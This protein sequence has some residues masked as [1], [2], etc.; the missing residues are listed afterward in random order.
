M[1]KLSVLFACAVLFAACAGNKNILNERMSKYPAEKYI[2]RIAAAPTKAAARAAA[3][4]DL[5]K[6][7]DGVP[8]SEG[9]EIRRQSILARASVVQWWRDKATDRFYAIAALE[10]AG[11]QTTM[12]PFYA[13]IDARLEAIVQRMDG[14]QDKFARLRSAMAMQPLLEQ[15]ENLDREFRLLS[16]DSGAFNEDRLFVFRTAYNKAF[17]DIR[18][19]AKLTGTGDLAVKTHLVDALNRLGF[20]VGENMTSA[21]IELSIDTR[22]THT[23]SKRVD[24]L[25]WADSTATIA[26]KDLETGG[27]FATFDKFGRDGSGRAEEAQRRSMIAVG[28]DSAPIIKQR[29]LEYIQRR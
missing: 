13:S 19:N 8:L 4:E 5:K 9:S 16:F 7:F 20:S 22:V 14:E 10:R 11:A 17:S 29:I 24:G 26:L 12:R 27:V 15:R 28:A 21:D 23:T 25:F 1:K 3:L 6:L 2:T 18:I